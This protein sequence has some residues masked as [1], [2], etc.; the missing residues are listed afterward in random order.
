MNYSNLEV[1]KIKLENLTPYEKNPKIHTEEQIQ[2]IANSINSFGFNDPIAVTGK[3][4]F[5]LEGHGRILALKLLGWTEAPCIRLEH[6]KTHEDRIAYLLSHNQATLNSGWDKT[7]LNTELASLMNANLNFKMS[8]FGFVDTTI[9]EAAL[10]Q[11]FEEVSDA[12]TE[13]DSED[14]KNT[15]S[16]TCPE[17]GFQFDLK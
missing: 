5:V 7:L 6:L 2:Q 17:C 8:D 10:D 15:K 4:N 16:C 12:G 14:T 11:F 1:V 13:A 9:D 3:E